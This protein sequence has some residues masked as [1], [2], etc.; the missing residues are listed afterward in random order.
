MFRAIAA[1]VIVVLAFA[2]AGAKLEALAIGDGREVLGLL[3]GAL[4]G[5]LVATGDR[6]VVWRRS[7][8]RELPT[9]SHAERHV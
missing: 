9:P 2:I 8:P 6:R 3:W 1:R 4:A 7:R 5:V